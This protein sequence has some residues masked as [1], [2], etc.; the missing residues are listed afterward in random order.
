MN[1]TKPDHYATLNVHPDATD[2]DIKRGYRKLMRAVHPDANKT[3]PDATKKAAALNRAFETLGDPAKR[4]AY[5]DE[6]GG[7]KS[8]RR[9]EIWAEQPDWEDIVAEQAVR[10][11]KPKHVHTQ[12]P[13]IVPEE[14]EVDMAELREQPRVRRTITVTNH[15]ECTLAGDV[16]TSEPWVWGPVGQIRIGPNQSASFDVEVIA[17][18]V[19][20][21]GL[22][23]VIFVTKD[24]SG[25]VPVKVT[26]YEPK[27]RKVPASAE[28]AYTPTRRRKWA[29]R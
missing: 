12:D 18:K 14:L 10:P 25:V 2:A 1:S 19:T 27:R 21:P 22:S 20:F 4:R 7:P 16:S 3:D 11:R 8:K 6:R 15:C 17:R 13:T 28:M 23:R 24:W 29:R 26:G 9:Y 5:D